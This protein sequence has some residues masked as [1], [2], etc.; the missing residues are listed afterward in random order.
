MLEQCKQRITTVENQGGDAVRRS[1]DLVDG[2]DMG[3][4]QTQWYEFCNQVRGGI[5][6]HMTGQIQ[7]IVSRASHEILEK[8]RSSGDQFRNEAGAQVD[9]LRGA[10]GSIVGG[11]ETWHKQLRS[12]N[13]K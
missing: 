11:W 1:G 3:L 5:H 4:N 10:Q 13:G 8:V 2:G 7:H 9:L 6:N 12:N